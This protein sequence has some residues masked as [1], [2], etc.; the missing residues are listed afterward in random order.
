MPQT[1][2]VCGNHRGRNP[3]QRDR[4]FF[5]TFQGVVVVAEVTGL[6]YDQV[7]GGMAFGFHIHEGTACEGNSADPFADTGAHYDKSDCPHPYHTGDMPPLFGN[8]GYAFSAFLTDRFSVEEIIGKTVVIHSGSDD[9][10]SQPSGNAGE[11]IACGVIQ[12]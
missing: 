4:L 1:A 8:H 12:S 6:P 2:G 3:H 10:M 9:F 7:C 5:Q 11:K